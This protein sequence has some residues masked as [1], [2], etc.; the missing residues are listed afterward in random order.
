M[1]HLGKEHVNGQ[2]REGLF[3]VMCYVLANGHTSI[4]KYCM[5]SSSY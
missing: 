2:E 1:I 5:Y 3:W 4:F